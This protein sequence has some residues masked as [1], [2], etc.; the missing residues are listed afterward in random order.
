MKNLKSIKTKPV[1]ATLLMLAIILPIAFAST[2][3][4]FA[5]QENQNSNTFSIPGVTNATIIQNKT[6]ITPNATR[7]QVKA[8]ELSLYCYRNATMLMN[9]TRNCELIF[10]MDP[11]LTPKTFGFN[12]DP[13]QTMAL[14]MNMSG[15]P[16]NGEQVM[17]RTLNFYLGIEPNATLQLQAQIRLYINQTQLNQELG[18]T[19]NASQLTW[20]FYNTSQN[21]WQAVPSYIDAEGYL[22]C[23]TNHFSSWTVAE[24]DN[25]IT[26]TNSNGFNYAT[27]YI[28]I[29]AVAIIVAVTAFVFVKRRK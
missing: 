21:A 10:T 22:V 18:R 6:D 28:C 24:V 5:L 16:L 23:N 17:T 14:T 1:I 15:S 20:M 29:S 26:D 25:T 3:N 9:C 27:I 7:E 2:P 19:V 8:G 11:S 12:V 4:V 13:N